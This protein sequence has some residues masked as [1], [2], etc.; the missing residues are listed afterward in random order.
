MLSE[1]GGPVF[2]LALPKPVRRHGV[3]GHSKDHFELYFKSPTPLHWIRVDTRIEEIPTKSLLS[4]L[5]SGSVFFARLRFPLDLTVK[6]SE[7]VISVDGE[8]RTFTIY[9]VRR[10]SV[11]MTRLADRWIYVHADK[12]ELPKLALKTERPTPL[13]R[14]LDR[15]DESLAEH[16]AR[17]DAIQARLAAGQPIDDL[18]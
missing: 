14:F 8:P 18:T 15:L 5:V 17:S 2:G 7:R 11:A 6:R 13:V 16:Y 9:T 4:A 10:H 1:M 12:A 3:V